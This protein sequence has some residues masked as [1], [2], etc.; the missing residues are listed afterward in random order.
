VTFRIRRRLIDPA[1]A[2]LNYQDTRWCSGNIIK[3]LTDRYLNP[4]IGAN[5][6]GSD[7]YSQCA[8]F[9]SQSGHQLSEVFRGIFGPL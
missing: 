8:R 3:Y 1:S 4:E 2:S 6:C 9:E 5:C 7:L